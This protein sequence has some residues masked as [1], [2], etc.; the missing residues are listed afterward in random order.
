MPAAASAR[1]G[2]LE[3]TRRHGLVADDRGGCAGLERRDACPEFADQ[4]AA[5]RDVVGA[6][7]ERDVD[8][9]GFAGAQRSSHRAASATFAAGAVTPSTPASAVTISFTIVSCDT[10][11]DTTVMSASA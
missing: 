3:M 7:A 6:R 4:S 8:G 5:D 9:D 2:G 1:L 10:S 11:R